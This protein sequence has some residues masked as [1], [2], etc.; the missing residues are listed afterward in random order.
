MSHGS[1]HSSYTNTKTPP[2]KPLAATEPAEPT[3]EF[4]YTDTQQNMSFYPDYI[5]RERINCTMLLG[6]RSNADQ[7]GQ[8]P[9]RKNS[10]PYGNMFYKISWPQNAL[11]THDPYLSS[12]FNMSSAIIFINLAL[13]FLCFSWVHPSF[14]FKHVH[15]AVSVRF[16]HFGHLHNLHIVLGVVGIFSP[17][18]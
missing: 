8:W 14:T 12:A 4:T 16:L 13:N 11:K 15:H 3:H 7:F 18:W 2:I 9:A 10:A 17:P 1:Y 5:K 6:G